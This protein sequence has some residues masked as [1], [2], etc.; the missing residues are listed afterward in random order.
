MSYADA[1]ACGSI[2][3]MPDVLVFHI[4]TKA[5]HVLA[6]E[7]GTCTISSL[8]GNPAL[9]ARATPQSAIEKIASERINRLLDFTVEKPCSPPD[10]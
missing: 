4:E 5:L 2:T 8:R 6:S 1:A 10:F 7:E 3:E 9:D